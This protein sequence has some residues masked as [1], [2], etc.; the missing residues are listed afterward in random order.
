M[1]SWFCKIQGLKSE[2]CDAMLQ[3]ITI[4]LTLLV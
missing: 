3:K 4:L 2:V 1:V